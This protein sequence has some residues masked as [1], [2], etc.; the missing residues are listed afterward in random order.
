MRRTYRRLLQQ[1][2]S[3]MHHVFYSVK[4]SPEHGDGTTPRG[5]A[6]TRLQELVAPID[7]ASRSSMDLDREAEASRGRRPVRVQ[8]SP[9][10]ARRSRARARCISR[11]PS[12]PGCRQALLRPTVN[13]QGI[14]SSC[15]ISQS[16]RVPP[17]RRRRSRAVTPV[18]TPGRIGRSPSL[19]PSCSRVG[20]FLSKSVSHASRVL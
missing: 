2:R 3:P 13:P 8:E 19:Q 16:S 10:P 15:W 18:A 12:G 14:V 20:L 6:R 5:H 4:S 11:G 9:P 7:P 1:M 17:G